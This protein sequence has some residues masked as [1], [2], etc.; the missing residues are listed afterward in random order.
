MEAGRELDAR[1]A[2]EIM[3]WARLATPFNTEQAVIV[4][5]GWTDLSAKRWLGH[6][7]LELVPPYSTDIAAAWP[8]AEKLRETHGEVWIRSTESGWWNC[9]IA[10][11]GV[12]RSAP[13]APE[14]ICLAA[15]A[16]LDT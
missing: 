6:P 12:N 13:T 1:I 11:T 8:V 14:A 7:L 5:P 16:T 3:G 9:R 2:I 15:L 4:P 10:E